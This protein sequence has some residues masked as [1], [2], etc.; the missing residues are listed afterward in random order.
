ML[1]DGL[2]G[3]EDGQNNIVTFNDRERE[4]DGRRLMPRSRHR[5]MPEMLFIPRRSFL[6]PFI[7]EPTSKLRE[8]SVRHAR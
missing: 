8:A 4:D 5:E 3:Y 2:E 6:P 1:A 7:C